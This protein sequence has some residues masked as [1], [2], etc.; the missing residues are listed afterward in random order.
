MLN[1]SFDEFKETYKL[2]RRFESLSESLFALNA[3]IQQLGHVRYK[4]LFV[5]YISC[6]DQFK[7]LF[8]DDFA[9]LGLEEIQ[10][11][12][13]MGNAL[14]KTDRLS[15]LLHQAQAVIGV[16]KGSLPPAFMENP[17]GTT[18][19]VSSQASSQS[20]AKA[21][22]QV[23]FTLVLEG[24]S[25]AIQDSEF[26]KESKDELIREIEEIKS[27]S[28]PDESRLKSFATKLG[29]KLQEISE[30]V[31]VEVIHKFLSSQMGQ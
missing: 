13:S 17:G 25:K 27:L 19:L 11:F 7:K 16:I 3:T 30:N 29:N 6:I 2:L 21:T 28:K 1:Y 22:A 24:L 31:V 18:I 12:D 23:Q 9:Q 4:P 26:S 8:L 14:Y 5:S 20:S 15:T 10:L